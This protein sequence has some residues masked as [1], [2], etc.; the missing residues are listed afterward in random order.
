MYMLDNL[1]LRYVFT[2]PMRIAR[3]RYMSNVYVCL[4]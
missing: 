1:V 4:S 3:G 2:V